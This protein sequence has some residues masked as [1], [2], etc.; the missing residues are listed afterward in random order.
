MGARG[1]DVAQLVLRQ[2]LAAVLLGVAIGFAG[3]LASTRLLAGMVYGISTT[4]PMTFVVVST[5]L[6]LIS[7]LAMVLP[8]RR[9]SRVDPLV[10]LRYE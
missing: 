6:A 3:A 2:G 5:I 7:A 8:A 9:A 4:D 1:N 10:A